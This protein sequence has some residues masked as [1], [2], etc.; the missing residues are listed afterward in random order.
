[1]SLQ[2]ASNIRLLTE[3]KD[4]KQCHI[5]KV[6]HLHYVDKSGRLKPFVK[7]HLLES[8]SLCVQVMVGRLVLAK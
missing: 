5:V 3:R 4:C 7:R 8:D 1:M 6:P 2:T